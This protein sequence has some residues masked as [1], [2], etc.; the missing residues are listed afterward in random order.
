MI[1]ILGADDSECRR[2]SRM[3]PDYTMLRPSQENYLQLAE[4]A[5]SL[6]KL[7]MLSTT[8]FCYTGQAVESNDQL[9]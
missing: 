8:Y 3:I 5:K 7:S 4:R 2:S 1:K 6:Q 9:I